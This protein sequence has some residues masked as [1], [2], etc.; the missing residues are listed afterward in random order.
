MEILVHLL[1]EYGL[2][3]T[4]ILLL[5]FIIYKGSLEI[6]L[7]YPSKKRRHIDEE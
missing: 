5:L 1:N 2:F 3:T 6:N 4:I 7:V